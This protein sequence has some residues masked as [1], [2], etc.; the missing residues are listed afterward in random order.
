MNLRTKLIATI[1]A[2]S[3]LP[4]VALAWISHTNAQKAL[5]AQVEASLLNSSSDRMRL[6]ETFFAE[7]VTDVRTWSNLGI[8]Q[9]LLTDD[10]EGELSAELA[11]LQNRYPHF[12]EITALNGEG[13]IVSSSLSERSD[14][15]FSDQEALFETASSA[16]L[17]QSPVTGDPMSGHPV[18]LLGVSVRASYDP[19]TVIGVLIGVVDWEKINARL[20]TQTVNAEPQDQHHRLVLRDSNGVTLYQTAEGTPIGNVD[21]PASSGIKTIDFDGRQYLTAT[22]HSRGHGEFSN[23]GW[24]LHE[25][26]DARIAYQAVTRLKNQALLIGALAIAAVLVASFMASQHI[27]RPIRRVVRRLKDISSGGGDLTVTL[28]VDGSDEISQLSAAF[29]DFV[30]KI[31]GIITTTAAATN[32]LASIVDESH[33]VTRQTQQGVLQQQAQIDQMASAINQMSA[34][35]NEVAS[36]TMEAAEAANDAQLQATN[37]QELIEETIKTIEQL[38]GEVSNAS[39]VI[40]ELARD[41]DQVGSVLGVIRNIAEQTNLLALNAAIEAARAGE[42]GR[43]FAVVA[44]EVRA[45]AQRTQNSI[46]EIEAIIERLQ[47]QSNKAVSVM[48]NGSRVATQGTVRVGDAGSALSSILTAVERI[49]RMNELIATSAQEQSHV[50]DEVNKNIL[51]IAEVAEQTAAGASQ[52][53]SACNEMQQQSRNLKELVAQFRT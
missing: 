25:M 34:T 11:R 33:Q 30:R 29:N 46:E 39:G 27:V 9:D 16:P 21:L 17:Y 53:A 22:Q 5:G 1:T 52:T 49:S 3:L 23:P 38:A 2:C 35:V 48:Q 51:V 7:S 13:R 42:S 50:A 36:N 43:G 28:E 18:L 4:L 10:E 24:Q 45:L 47:S 44:D 6:L 20:S 8:M 37:G 40:V 14:T 12:S 19:D 26:L 32:E 15:P 41:S 31:R